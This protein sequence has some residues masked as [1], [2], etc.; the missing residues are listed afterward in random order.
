M[1][2]CSKYHFADRALT[3]RYFTD[4]TKEWYH[5]CTNIN[6]SCKFVT[7]ETVERFIVSQGQQ[8][9]HWM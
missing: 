5:Q 7:T 1:F 9:I 8:Q 3:S 6:C 2:H 4:T